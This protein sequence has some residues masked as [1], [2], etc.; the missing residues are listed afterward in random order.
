M[1]YTYDLALV[2]AVK[3]SVLQLI[4]GPISPV[5]PTKVHIT[6]KVTPGPGETGLIT[7]TSDTNNIHKSFAVKRKQIE[8]EPKSSL[9]PIFEGFEGSIANHEQR[10]LSYVSACFTFSSRRTKNTLLAQHHTNSESKKLVEGD[11]M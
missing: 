9:R 4:Q 1:S 3:H 2:L 10:R 11:I 6:S 8:L 7:M 5:P